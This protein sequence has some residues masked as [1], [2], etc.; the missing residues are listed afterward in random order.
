[1]AADFFHEPAPRLLL[2]GAGGL[3]QRGLQIF[4]LAL[5]LVPWQKIEP[6]HQDRGFDHRGLGAVE[7]L[8][9]GMG[10]AAHQA[11]VEARTLLVLG[12][13]GDLE[14]GMRP[15]GRVWLEVGRILLAPPAELGRSRAWRL[16]IDPNRKHPKWTWG[17]NGDG[18]A[19]LIPRILHPPPGSRRARA[20][21]PRPQG[22]R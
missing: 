8:E 6:A 11:A 12:D 13:M 9:R 17:R 10:D 4:D 16:I 20:S 1:M 18:G 2:G 3:L 14:L 22:G 15:R 5:D 7:A 19:C 21:R